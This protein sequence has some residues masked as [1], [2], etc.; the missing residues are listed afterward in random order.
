MT[1]GLGH[2]VQ[3]SAR[4][5][6]VSAAFSSVRLSAGVTDISVFRIF[7][8]VG[9]IAS[10]TVTGIV[11]SHNVTDS[12]MQLVGRILVVVSIVMLAPTVFDHTLKTPDAPPS[13]ART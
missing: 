3:Q 4:R 10:S 1:V 12:G 7:G 13:A 6:I 5:S 11:F 9:S 8:Y 2:G